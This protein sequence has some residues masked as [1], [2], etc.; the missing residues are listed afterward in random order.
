MVSLGASALSFQDTQISKFQIAFRLSRSRSPV[1]PGEFCRISRWI[2]PGFYKFP[3]GNGATNEYTTHLAAFTL[4]PGVCK[5]RVKYYC[6]PET[7]LA[8]GHAGAC[9]GC[10]SGSS[11]GS[12][13]RGG[14]KSSKSSVK[15]PSSLIF[16][17]LHCVTIVRLGDLAYPGRGGNQAGSA[18]V[19]AIT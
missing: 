19:T 18:W 15:R 7:I 13:P 17:T 16:A 5:N 8:I 3:Q 10:V 4:I 2:L 12:T 14:K 9:A 6:S 11:A 1:K